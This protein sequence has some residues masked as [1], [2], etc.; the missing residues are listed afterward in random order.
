MPK[1][2]KGWAMFVVSVMIVLFLI[3]NVAFLQGLVN[4]KVF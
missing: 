4:R 2:I 3:N 1:S